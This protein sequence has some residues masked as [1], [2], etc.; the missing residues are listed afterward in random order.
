[1]KSRMRGPEASQS[2]SV[3]AKMFTLGMPF[4]PRE[5]QRFALLPLASKLCLLITAV[6][7]SQRILNCNAELSSG[8]GAS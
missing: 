4:L 3:A 1:M 6:Q 8:L 5:K 2:I 7:N